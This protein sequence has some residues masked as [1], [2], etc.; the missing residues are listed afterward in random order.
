MNPLSKLSTILPLDEM[1]ISLTT[2][3]HRREANKDQGKGL[4][5]ADASWWC[6]RM[7]SI[8]I[9]PLLILSR[10]KWQSISMCLVRSLRLD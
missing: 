7:G 6:E 5:K 3:L 10:T 2:I 9:D 8:L 1:Y 4:V